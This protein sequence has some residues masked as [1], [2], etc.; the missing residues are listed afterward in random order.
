MEVLRGRAVVVTGASS[1]IGQAVARRCAGEG[2][3]VLAVGRRPEGLEET[4]AGHDG[5]TTHV[6]DLRDDD[7]PADVVAVAVERFGRLD[8]LVH[9]AGTV[10]RGEDPLATTD[11][12]H[13]ELVT[14]NLVLP[15]RMAREAARAMVDD[16][17]GSVVLVSSQL[18]HVG[19]PGYASYSAAKGGVESLVRALAVDLGP[20]GVR[21]NALAPGVVRTPMAYVDR[22]HFDDMIDDVAARHPLRRIGEP[23]DLAGPAVFLLGDDSRWM[24]GASLVVDGGYTIQ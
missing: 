4:A 20:R 2:A 1:G 12:R 9:A 10:L 5:I 11:V 22:E 6:A 13:A 17:G 19:A 14:D 3:S 18:A 8:G 23:D 16:G 7:A 24:T 21:V 15:F